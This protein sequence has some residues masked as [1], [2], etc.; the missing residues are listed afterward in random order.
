MPLLELIIAAAAITPR[1]R[2]D[3]YY[4]FSPFSADAIAMLSWLSL[5]YAA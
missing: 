4:F 5:R 1:F 3:I 2:L